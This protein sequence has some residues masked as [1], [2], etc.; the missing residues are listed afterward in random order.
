MEIGA[1]GVVETVVNPQALLGS[2]QRQVI[3][4]DEVGVVEF[5]VGRTRVRV[6]SIEYCRACTASG[7]TGDGHALVVADGQLAAEHHVANIH[8]SASIH[9]DRVGSF[10][11]VGP[12]QR[13]QTGFR[14]VRRLAG[15]AIVAGRSG[16]VLI[17]RVAAVINEETVPLNRHRERFARNIRNR[18]IRR[19]PYANAIPSRHAS[20][21]GG[22]SP[23]R[24]AKMGVRI[25]IHR[26]DVGQK[27]SVR[28]EQVDVHAAGDVKRMEENWMRDAGREINEEVR[29]VHVQE[30]GSRHASQRCVAVRSQIQ[31]PAVRIWLAAVI[32]GD[33]RI[34]RVE[35]RRNYVGQS[36]IVRC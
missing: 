5:D 2:G 11:I 8:V 13:D 24:R 27:V 36:V 20:Q 21:R 23:C 30:T 19:R 25:D 28:I 22:R 12:Q 16:R 14:I 4:R 6:A 29:I 15:V 32:D 18:V 35:T 33:R 10:Q 17:E 9:E 26:R 34:A 3:D 1:A 31:P 7:R